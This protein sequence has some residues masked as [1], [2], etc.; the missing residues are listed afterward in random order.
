MNLD[1]FPVTKGDTVVVLGANVGHASK[2]YSEKVGANGKVVSVEP[3]QINYNTLCHKVKDL[4]NVHPYMLAIGASPHMGVIN[5]GTLR[6]NH[7]TVREFNGVTQRVEVV[8]WDTLMMRANL[9]EVSLAKVD[10]EGA[11]ILWLEGMT[12]TFPKH[13]IMEEHSRFAYPLEELTVLLK[14]KG[15]MWVKK[16]NHI[17]ATK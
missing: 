8:S 5:I 14:A 2:H 12:H 10:V 11:E 4:W 1:Y 9:T 17:Y 7:S 13:V 15:Y 6:I 3:E 16:G